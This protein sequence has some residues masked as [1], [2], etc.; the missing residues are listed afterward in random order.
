MLDFD[1]LVARG[2]SLLLDAIRDEMQEGL[3]LDFKAPAVGKQGAAFNAQGQLTKEGRAAI[4]KALSAF[5]NSAGGVL[6]FGVDCRKRVDGVDCATDLEPIPNWKAAHSAVSGAVG[7][8]LQP[9]ND[10]IRVQGFASSADQN[11]GYIV[12]DVPRSERRPHR[13][14][15]A[16]QKQYFKRSG[17]ASY[18]MEHFDIEDAFRRN[19]SPDLELVWDFAGHM[20]AGTTVNASVTLAIKNQ[21]LASAKHVSLTIVEM[22]GIKT[23]FGAPYTPPMTKHQTF[24]LVRRLIAS[25]TFVVNPGDVQVFDQLGIEF[26]YAEP[27]FTAGGV[28]LAEASFALQY[29]LS[30]EN[31]R[32][33]AG[34]LTLSPA[35]FERGARKFKPAYVKMP[36]ASE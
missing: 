20:S 33:K 8:L 24:G 22:S 17:S 26:I 14:E 2:E 6:V 12:I 18:P 21:G 30:A 5:S 36:G 3:S 31:M 32:P 19:G 29:S 1:D 16:D 13:S 34:T 9:K 27:M 7:D 10:S 35:D 11:A 15:A 23:K 28:P 4:A 25:E